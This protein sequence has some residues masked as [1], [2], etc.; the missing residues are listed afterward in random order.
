MPGLVQSGDC[1]GGRCD[2]KLCFLM[3]HGSMRS[4]GQGVYLAN[5][6]RE[7]TRLGHEV[8][9]ISAPPYPM[10]DGAVRH[11]LIDER[12]FEAMLLDRARFFHARHPLAHF[13]PLDL[14]EFASTRLT[15]SSLL[16]VFGLRAL[17]RLRT[18]EEA[19]GAFDVVHDN[20]S[21]GY[22]LLLM[23]AGRGRPVVANV[24]HPLEVDLQNALRHARS[25][26][27]KVRRIAW[28]PWHMQ[29]FVARR[30]DALITGSRA[31]AALVAGLWRLPPGLVQPIYDGVDVQTFSPGEGSEKD[32]AA[33]VFVG[34][35]EDHNK[36][37]VYL[38]RAMALLPAGG[39]AHLFIVGG[40]ARPQR[41]APA[42]IARLGMEDRVT[43]VGPVDARALA[44]WYRRAQVVACPS[45][46]EGFGLPVV[47]A[48]ASQTAVVATDAGALPEIVADGETGRIV[49]SADARALA[50]ALGGL[51]NRPERCA[52]MGA[53]GRA[54]V[55]ERFTWA[56][57]ACATERLYE[58]ILAKNRAA[59]GGN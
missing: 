9:V 15:L 51:L 36:G 39:N 40:A 7:L 53:A 21:L 10:L 44:G 56:R 54:R 1:A 33:I 43:I 2:I 55:L 42:E 27:E 58:A 28:H 38:L 25:L 47:E 8:H 14:Y 3:Y 59:P 4:G 11:H 17:V 52:E 13:H 35:S 48:M 22:G 37:I 6:T 50:D 24:H 30:L 41:V 46:Y 31:S 20:Q 45:I 49:A 34:N 12:S 23:R 29:R 26:R 57:T 18:V 32:R 5:I 16:M 19:A